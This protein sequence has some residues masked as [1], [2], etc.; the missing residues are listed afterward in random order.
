MAG[1][2]I[3]MYVGVF[4]SFL[5]VVSALQCYQC[6]MYSDGVGS[7]TPCLNHT[8]TKL[9]ECPSREHR[10]C[11]VSFYNFSLIIFFITKIDYFVLLKYN[12]IKK[13]RDG[14]LNKIV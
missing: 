3:S 2:N 5:S 10:F 12:F 7:I 9:I 14:F 4:V 1:Y 13:N 6:G 8:H 11:I